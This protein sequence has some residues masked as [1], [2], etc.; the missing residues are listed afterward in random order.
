M[1]EQQGH[2][3]MEPVSGEP[4]EVDGVY[5]NEWGREEKLSR[6]D[7]FPAD[8]QLG[9]TEWEL[10]QLDFE[11]HHEGKTDVRLVA[12]KETSSLEAHLQHPRR[13][14]KDTKETN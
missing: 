5:K 1:S 3:E 11:N 4:V 6:G 7:I 9:T 12:K 13:H 2:F 14:P 8:P 10:T